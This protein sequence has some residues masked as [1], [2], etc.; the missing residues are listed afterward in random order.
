MCDELSNWFISTYG[1]IQTHHISSCFH[2]GCT[3]AYCMW[4]IFIFQPFSDEV[5]ARCSCKNILVYCV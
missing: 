4:I 5:H 3:H 2:I 1:P